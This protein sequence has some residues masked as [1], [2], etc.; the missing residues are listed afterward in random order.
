MLL[1]GHIGLTLATALVINNYLPKNTFVDQ[2]VLSKN[3]Y[4]TAKTNLKGLSAKFWVIIQRA[5]EVDLRFVIIG[6]LLPDIID[7]PIGNYFLYNEFGSG[8]LFS[9][10]LLFVILLF[11]IGYVI[12]LIYKKYFILLLAFG[13]FIHLILDFIWLNKRIFL[14]PLFGFT[15]EKGTSPPFKEWIWG[16][17][18]EVLREPWVAIPELVG[19]LITIWFFWLLWRQKKLRTFIMRGQI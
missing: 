18:V 10:T 11:L 13:S 15:F 5:K 3:E 16:M 17:F 9:H 1:F 19:V 2:K 4:N 14:W 8:Y 12:K 6:S 7:K